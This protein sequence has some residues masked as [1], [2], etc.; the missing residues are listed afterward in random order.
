MPG[1]RP[2][3]PFCMIGVIRR[4]LRLAQW[5]FTTTFIRFCQALPTAPMG[6]SRANHSTGTSFLSL[7]KHR[8]SLFLERA[9]HTCNCV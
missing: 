2:E 6:P 9:S 8:V 7:P 5:V 3:A 4:S 1:A